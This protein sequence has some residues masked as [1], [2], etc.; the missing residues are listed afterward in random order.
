MC[1]IPQKFFQVCRLCLVSIE[2]NDILTH[3]ICD[4][5]EFHKNLF[6]DC[7]CIIN[8]NKMC[9]DLKGIESTGLIKHT[10]GCNKHTACSPEYV[11]STLGS[12]PKKSN[13]SQKLYFGYNNVESKNRI[14]NEKISY[15]CENSD[16]LTENIRA[17]SALNIF[18]DSSPSI[19]IQILS[20]LSLE[21]CMRIWK[22]S[23]EIIHFLFDIHALLTI[24]Y[25]K[26]KRLFVIRRFNYILGATLATMHIFFLFS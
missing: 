24:W 4:E 1:S 3:R 12:I 18:D 9:V 14:T 2:E 10:K 8:R 15:N 5:V 21:V 25:C 17:K 20:C 23:N 22:C 13:D 26:C 19:V 6:T 7:S 11:P 16:F